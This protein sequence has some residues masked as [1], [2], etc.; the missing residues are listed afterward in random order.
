MKMPIPSD[1]D[2]FSVCN[3]EVQWPDSPIWRIILR[4]LLTNP[5]LVD[6]WDAATG[7]VAQVLRDFEPFLNFTLNELE[8][9]AMSIPVGT[10]WEFAGS[11]LPDKFLWADGSKVLVAD[12]PDLYGVIGDTFANGFF[13]PGVDFYLPRRSGR[14]SVGVDAGQSEFAALGQTGGEKTHTL[15]VAQMPS[16]T[17]IQNSHNHAQNAHQHTIPRD[18]VSG[19]S[20][21]GFSSP[22]L[23]DVTFLL[24]STTATN[25][26]A[27]AT[28][29]NTGEG[30]PHNNLQ[31]YLALNFII[32]AKK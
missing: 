4:G 30:Q 3:Y 9:N 8:C 27:T 22:G 7:N 17:H 15:T 10:I 12:Y 29:Q 1:W 31:P 23:A 26:P 25:Q 5:S 13:T 24:G 14:V 19:G 28:N 20:G 32:R 11:T 18:T 21:V 2:G 16:H 6:F